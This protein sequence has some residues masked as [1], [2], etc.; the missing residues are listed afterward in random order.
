MDPFSVK[1]SDLIYIHLNN[2]VVQ[3]INNNARSK[4]TIKY[5]TFIISLFV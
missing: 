1:V 3:Y 5:L 4:P 2:N